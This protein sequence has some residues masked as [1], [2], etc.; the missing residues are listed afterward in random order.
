[1]HHPLRVLLIEDDWTV[2]SAVAGYLSRRQM[3]IAEADCAEQAL[4]VAEAQRPHYVLSAVVAGISAVAFVQSDHPL[5]NP[6]GLLYLTYIVGSLAFTI[7]WGLAGL[8]WT[9]W[10]APSRR[11]R[12]QSGLIMLSLAVILLYMAPYSL[13]RCWWP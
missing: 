7:L 9:F 2:R 12:R 10:R 3:E 13:H 8:A 1:M 6:V 5:V 4:E 11:V